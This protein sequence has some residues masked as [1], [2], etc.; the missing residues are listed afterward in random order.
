M[1]RSKAKRDGE[2]REQRENE[3]VRAENSA[4]VIGKNLRRPEK[5]RRK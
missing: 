5:Q 1:A 4:A 3:T 2:T